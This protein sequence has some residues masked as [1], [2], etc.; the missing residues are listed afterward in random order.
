MKQ[1]PTEFEVSNGII[2]DYGLFE[3][4]P[5]YIPQFYDQ[6]MAGT[7]DSIEV[8][9]GQEFAIFELTVFD[10]DQYPDLTGYVQL[11]LWKEGKFL[12]YSLAEA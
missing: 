3:N 11:T 12:R 5:E 8:Q 6:W 7:A 9:D 4:L 10:S 1:L 2:Q